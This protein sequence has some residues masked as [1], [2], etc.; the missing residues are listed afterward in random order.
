MTTTA[1][2][3]DENAEYLSAAIAWL[4]LLL[5]RASPAE[6]DTR[7]SAKKDSK[8]S[9][10]AHS[11]DPIQKAAARM[12][13]LAAGMQS[14]PAL[15]LLGDVLGLSRFELDI[16][17]LCAAAEFDPSMR[18]L[19]A[20]ASRCLLSEGG[21]SE[22]PTFALALALFKS[23]S[24]D[25]LSP[26][27]ALR[28]WHLVE[29][30]QPGAQPLASSALHA[31]ERIVDF[32]KGLNRL[33][34]RL[35]PY[36]SALRVPDAMAELPASQ[37]EIGSKILASWQGAQSGPVPLV[38]LE[39]PN[40]DSKRRIA[41]AV[42]ATLSQR[43]YRLSADALP[44]HAAE[45]QLLSRLWQRESLLMPVA[46]FIDAQSAELSE[47][48]NGVARRFF[49]QTSG[50]FFLAVRESWARLAIESRS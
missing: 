44:A 33:D 1:S 37:Q 6:S 31:D 40:Y 17:L 13:S 47:S 12:E 16:L 11:D 3:L 18:Q 49:A 34:D 8:A 7:A 45:V 35:A 25:A 21:A 26:E 43:L 24:W 23:P 29:I 5:E 38:Q 4:R 14:S 10:S 48:Q 30:H 36:V 19:C 41:G 20:D 15:L 32:L 46:L 22:S 39:G 2:W 28:Y 42:A 9:G 50:F 27:R